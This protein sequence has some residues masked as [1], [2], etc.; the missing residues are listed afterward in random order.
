[1]YKTAYLLFIVLILASSVSSATAAD[2]VDPTTGMEFASI[3]GTEM[4]ITSNGNTKKVTIDTFMMGIFEVTF[5]QYSKFTSVTGAPIPDDNG[6]GRGKRPVIFVS[7]DEA[8]AFTEWLS[9]E[10]GKTFRL[11]TET[12]WLHAARGGALTTYPW[13]ETAPSPHANCANCGSQWLLGRISPSPP[14][15][16]SPLLPVGFSYLNRSKLI[17]LENTELF[18]LQH[19]SY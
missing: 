16:K 11:P 1:M 15:K 19:L 4:K 13:D 14:I 7:W 17:S 5:E 18:A 8:V 3:P 12:E 6:W 2:Y 10:T 9:E